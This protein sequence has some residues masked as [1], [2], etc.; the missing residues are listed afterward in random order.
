MS[1]RPN[2]M[3]TTSCDPFLAH[4]IRLWDMVFAMKGRASQED[5]LA[6]ALRSSAAEERAV[7]AALLNA[8]AARWREVTSKYDWSDGGEDYDFMANAADIYGRAA[9]LICA[10]GEVAPDEAPPT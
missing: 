3:V 8:E 2:R 6:T 10:R 4:A 7:C 1:D 9:R 5:L